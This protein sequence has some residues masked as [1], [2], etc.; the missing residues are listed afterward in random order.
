MSLF[1][2]RSCSETSTLVAKAAEGTLEQAARDRLMAHLVG[3]NRCR[4]Q[5]LAEAAAD[6]ALTQVA[7][8]PLG[9]KTQKCP[10]DEI[11]EAFA[12][13]TLSPGE[14][15]DWAS[16]VAECLYCQS[17]IGELRRFLADTAEAL[18]DLGITVPGR[19]ASQLPSIAAQVRSLS[20]AER[21]YSSGAWVSVATVVL[22]S[23]AIVLAIVLAPRGPSHPIGPSSV[24]P[25]PSLASKPAAPVAPRPDTAVEADKGEPG[26]QVEPPSA[27]NAPKPPGDTRGAAA[28]SARPHRVHQQRRRAPGRP[29]EPEQWEPETAVAR[30]T[31]EPEQPINELPQSVGSL[32]LDGEASML[33]AMAA[34]ARDDA[35]QA[36]EEDINPFPTGVDRS[37]LHHAAHG[38]VISAGESISRNAP[39]IPASMHE[40]TEQQ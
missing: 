39:G 7:R 19:G 37:L 24:S 34:R 33:S 11:L 31:L 3:C 4:K 21:R 6:A 14:R 1:T 27:G 8:Q 22:V 18:P 16:H 32:A 15:H 25:G 23:T 10:P 38:N 17:E 40:E 26:V 36:S 12:T 2:L 30:N 28:R 29:V 5:V 20:P 35:S 9:A 13:A